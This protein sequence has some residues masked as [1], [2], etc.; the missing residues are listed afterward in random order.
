MDYQKHHYYIKEAHQFTRQKYFRSIPRKE[1]FSLILPLIYTCNKHCLHLSQLFLQYFCS[2]AALKSKFW[3]IR[4][5]SINVMMQRDQS[6]IIQV[7]SIHHFFWPY[8]CPRNGQLNHSSTT[9]VLKLELPVELVQTQLGPTP[10]SNSVFRYWGGPINFAFLSG[11]QVMPI[12]LI[13]GPCFETYCMLTS[14]HLLNRNRESK[15]KSL[16]IT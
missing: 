8:Q 2:E 15:I 5:A 4:Y 3:D 9:A 16:V 13:Q 12:L 10:I 14:V 1:F 6:T 7:F 11:S